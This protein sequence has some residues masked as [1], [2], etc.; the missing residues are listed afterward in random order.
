[1]LNMDDH[2][3]DRWTV[4]RFELMGI[5]IFPP[6]DV[7]RTVAPEG[8]GLYDPLHDRQTWSK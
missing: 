8:T 6:G 3:L 5:R 4:Q 7:H 2:Y 1:M